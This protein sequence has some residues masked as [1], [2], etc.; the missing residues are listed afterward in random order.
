MVTASL[1]HDPVDNQHEPAEPP[2]AS[3]GQRLTPRNQRRLGVLVG[4]SLVLALLGA[5]SAAASP[6]Q[7]KQAQAAPQAE[8][9]ASAD[10]AKTA[11]SSLA[12]QKAAIDAAV[13]QQQAIL[14]KVKGDLAALLAQQ[15]AAAAA[16]AQR[17]AQ[18]ALAHSG[19]VRSRGP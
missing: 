16:D 6:I 3:G 17:R 11:A 15:Q 18:A 2:K 10:S 19:S 12:S 7:D 13:A 9:K 4:I 5:A 1:S 8:R 14:S